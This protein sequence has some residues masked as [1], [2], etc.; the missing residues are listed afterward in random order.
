ME[1][2]TF[3]KAQINREQVAKIKE[4]QNGNYKM[5]IGNDKLTEHY[6]FFDKQRFA[7]FLEKELQILNDEFDKL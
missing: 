3:V 5:F 2:H 4:I 1:I 6:N 7:N